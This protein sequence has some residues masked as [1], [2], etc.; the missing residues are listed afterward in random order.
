MSLSVHLFVYVVFVVRNRR[1]K[2]QR[3]WPEVFF[4]P[5]ATLPLSRFS[6][7]NYETMVYIYS[8]ASLQLLS[9]YLLCYTKPIQYTVLWSGTRIISIYMY[10]LCS[11][12]NLKKNCV[13][14]FFFIQSV[15]YAN[16]CALKTYIS[17]RLYLFHIVI[18]YIYILF[19]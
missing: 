8:N 18:Y 4:R 7:L 10:I 1:V 6:P 3:R 17:R 14:G 12:L 16:C 11:W 5:L 13:D 9:L 19:V 2:R 15:Y